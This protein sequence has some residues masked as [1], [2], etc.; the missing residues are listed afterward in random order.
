[1]KNYQI[2]ISAQW[3]P[4]TLERILRVVRHRGFVA[5]DLQSHLENQQVKMELTVQSE[6]AL[7]LLTNQ[8][9]KLYGVTDVSVISDEN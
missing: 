5:V 1:M 2:S 9:T 8:L 4:E 7:S 6:R 3:R